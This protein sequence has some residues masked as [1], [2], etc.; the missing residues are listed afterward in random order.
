MSQID[1]NQWIPDVDLNAAPGRTTRSRNTIRT[2]LAVLAEEA[3]RYNSQRQAI[4]RLQQL[5]EIH[6]DTRMDFYLRAREMLPVDWITSK[7]MAQGEKPP[8]FF[9]GLCQLMRSF[10][11]QRTGEV[12]RVPPIFY[13]SR[14]VTR[15]R[16]RCARSV[17][18]Q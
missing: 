11:W 5:I 1:E 14:V 8:C 13:G 6:F 17:A 18:D 12:K 15:C 9:L 2:T 4:N 10:G 7:E 3:S 16:R